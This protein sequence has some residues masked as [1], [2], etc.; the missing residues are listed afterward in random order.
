MMLRDFQTKFRVFHNITRQLQQP[1]KGFPCMYKAYY[2]TNIF[3][4]GNKPAVKL[5]LGV[6]QCCINVSLS[7]LPVKQVR[8][9]QRSTHDNR[10]MCVNVVGPTATKNGLREANIHLICSLNK[11]M[12]KWY[13]KMIY[14]DLTVWLTKANV[15]KS[16]KSWRNSVLNSPL[17]FV[18]WK[19][20]NTSFFVACRECRWVNRSVKNQEVRK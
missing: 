4:I 1:G 6:K 10:V 17:C 5:I 8:R 16:L 7:F 9:L 12:H 2:H 18:S 13:N 3:V 15:S 20:N 19:N 14:F 11:P